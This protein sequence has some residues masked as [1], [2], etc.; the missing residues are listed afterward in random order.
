M[1]T[2]GQP[3]GATSPPAGATPAGV[4]P[5]ADADADTL[6]TAPEPIRFSSPPCALHEIDEQYR[7]F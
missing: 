6:E 1:S 5:D 4:A 2:P 3:P 7:G